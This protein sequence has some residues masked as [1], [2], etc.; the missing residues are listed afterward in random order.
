M[1]RAVK[2]VTVPSDKVGGV[3]CASCHNASLPHGMERSNV[4]NKTKVD[5]KVC[6]NCHNKEWSPNFNLKTYLPK[7]T[8]PNA[9][10]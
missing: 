8:H 9:A 10:K 4:V 5:E 2:R 3:D 1:Y 7:V 6:M